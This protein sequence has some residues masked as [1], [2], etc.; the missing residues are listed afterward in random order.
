MGRP[1]RNSTGPGTPMPTPH[2]GPGMP[3]SSSEERLEQDVDSVEAGIRAVLDV[4]PARRGAPR[5]RPSRVVTAT[6][7]LVAPRSATRTWPASARN[8][9]WRGGRPPVLGPTSPS[10]TRPRSI[11]SPT[12]WATIAR[13]S[14]VRVTSS[15]RD[16][17]R[18]RRTSSRTMTSASSA[19]SGT[20]PWLVWT[21]S[22]RGS[23][24]QAMIGHIGRRQAGF[25]C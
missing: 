16:L 15:D 10:T 3:V 8:A 14:P 24:A 4:A 19:S 21:C 12:R 5:I 6:S 23:I 2:R 25:C 1:V 13:P 9:S 18:P 17:E 11:S 22:A 7:M 20:G